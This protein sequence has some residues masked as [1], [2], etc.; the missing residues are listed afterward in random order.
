MTATA[1]TT[2]L[3]DAERTTADN[4]PDPRWARPALIALLLATATF[5]TIGLSRNGWGNSF[6]AAAV[7]AGTQSWKA[8]LFGSSDAANTITVDKPPASLW[9]ME[10]STRLFGVNSWAMQ[11]PQ[12][13]L[14][15]ASV[16][17]R[18]RRG[19][20]AVRAGGG[21]DRRCPAG[22]DAGGYVDVPL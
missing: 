12:V 19:A 10:I 18:L 3:N 15:V 14:G 2:E 17:A 21:S 4:P 16:G 13:L 9:V 22:A 5:W 7:Q 11:V 20:T 8:F 1:N 6:Y